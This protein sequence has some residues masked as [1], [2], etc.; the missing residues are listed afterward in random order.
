M[1]FVQ[2]NL[3]VHPVSVLVLKFMGMAVVS[4]H[5]AVTIRD[6][7]VT[8]EDHELMRGFWVLRSKVPEVGRIIS[9]GKVGCWVSL[10]SVLDES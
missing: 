1:Y 9:V 2:S 5:L 8:E 3:P 10:L 4:M 7:S 6:T